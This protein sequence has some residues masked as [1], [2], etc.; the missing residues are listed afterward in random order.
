MLSYI[1]T[2]SLPNIMRNL[3]SRRMRW[4]GH[5]ACIEL[6]RNTFKIFMT[7]PEVERPLGRPRRR[8]ENSIIKMDLREI[9]CDAGD[10][11][12]LAE[13]SVQWQAYIRMVMNLWLP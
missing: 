5:V 6:S 3:K 2:Y 7:K 1:A 11:I 9:G 4:A 13:D 12:D 10:W 8:S